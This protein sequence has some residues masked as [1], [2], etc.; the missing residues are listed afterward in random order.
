MRS[1][2]NDLN[3]RVLNQIKSILS[4]RQRDDLRPDGRGAVRLFQVTRSHPPSVEMTKQSGRSG[5]W[6]KSRGELGE[7]AHA[8]PEMERSV[9][10]LK[11]EKTLDSASLSRWHGVCFMCGSDST[12]GVAI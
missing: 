7:I 3:K 10:W 6:G 2:S 4:R 1:G 11:C 12:P 9:L 8:C 5:S